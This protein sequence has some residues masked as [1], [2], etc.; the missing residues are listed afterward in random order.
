MSAT[1][2]VLAP[3]SNVYI[4]RKTGA[5]RPRALAGLRPGILEN[6]KPNA[7]LLMEAL[8]EGLHARVGL[9]AVTVA[10]K[11]ISVPPKKAALEELQANCD[12]VLV[13]TADC[14]SCTAGTVRTAVMLEDLGIPTVSTGTDVFRRQFETEAELLGRPD[15]SLLCIPHPLGGL[16]A[17]EVRHKARACIDELMTRLVAGA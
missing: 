4:P 12:F 16:K 5:P 11:P 9:K 10:H 17:S 2:R 6:T 13:G 3:L 1:I 8:I 7:Q 15:L 14:G